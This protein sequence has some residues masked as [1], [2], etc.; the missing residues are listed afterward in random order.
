MRLTMSEALLN[1]F[2][3][4]KLYE[5]IYDDSSISFLGFSESHICSQNLTWHMPVI[6]A[7]GRTIGIRTMSLNPAWSM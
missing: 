2:K 5:D 7:L 3:D 6:I 1:M 4:E